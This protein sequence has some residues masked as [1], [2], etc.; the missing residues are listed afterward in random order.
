M[1]GWIR[2]LVINSPL[3]APSSAAAPTPPVMA[4][5]LPCGHGLHALPFPGEEEARQIRLER[6]ATVGVADRVRES[7]DV[8]VETDAVDEGSG[9]VPVSR[10][11]PLTST[12]YDTVVVGRPYRMLN[13]NKEPSPPQGKRLKHLGSRWLPFRN[14]NVKSVKT[15]PGAMRSQHSLRGLPLFAL[16]S[17]R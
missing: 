5:A 11:T 10:S 9:H 2:A 4:A 7:G 15:S 6:P 17:P 8:S 14:S 3:H 12:L 13:I 1:N 16:S